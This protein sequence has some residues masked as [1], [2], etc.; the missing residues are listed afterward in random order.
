MLDVRVSRLCR[1]LED[2]AVSERCGWCGHERAGK[3]R[4]CREC[5]AAPCYGKR[6]FPAPAPPE[7]EEARRCVRCSAFLPVRAPAYISQ[8]APCDSVAPAPEPK[9]E[10]ARESTL[11]VILKRRPLHEAV[12]YLS[13]SLRDEALAVSLR[14][15]LEATAPPSGGEGGESGKTKDG[16]AS[17]GH[18]DHAQR[19]DLRPVHEGEPSGVV[20]AAEGARAGLEPG[21]VDDHA[22]GATGLAAPPCCVRAD[23]EVPAWATRAAEAVLRLER[24]GYCYRSDEVDALARLIAEAHHR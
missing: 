6:C 4:N 3:N 10:G 20:G 11:T 18:Q 16:S 2:A 9:A 17:L 23:G 14:A 1:L 21:R 12:R 7:P 5:A 8:C 15:L 24:R 19:E 13:D 22:A